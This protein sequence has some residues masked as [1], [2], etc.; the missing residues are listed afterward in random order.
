MDITITSLQKPRQ[1]D[2]V[3]LRF[4]DAC[5]N[6][7]LKYYAHDWMASI[8]YETIEE[9]D[10]V[11]SPLIDAMNSTH[12]SASENIKSVYRCTEG[13]VFR[14]WKLSKLGITYLALNAPHKNQMASR[15]QLKILCNYFD[16]KSS[17]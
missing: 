11:I 4:V 6:Q 16:Q 3:F 14:D 10:E 12:M 13:R 5:D 17:S 7:K 1:D 15:L 2:P 9:L 8:G